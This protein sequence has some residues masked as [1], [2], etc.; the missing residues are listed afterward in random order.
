MT[1][2]VQRQTLGFSSSDGSSQLKG[3]LWRSSA[4]TSSPRGIVQIVHGMSEYVG[5]YEEFAEALAAAGFVVC[6][7]DHIG[8]GKSVSDAADLG[9]IPLAAGAQA[10]IDDVDALRCLVAA[11]Y[12]RN[13]P[14]YLFGHSMGSFIVQAYLQE[15]W[16]GLAGAVLCGTGCQPVLASR[17]GNKLARLIAR[18][19]GER[20]VSTLLFRLADGAYARAVENPRTSFDWLSHNESNVD[21]Y[22]ADELCGARFTAAG[23]AALTD[24]TERAAR[25][26]RA[27][28][29]PVDL[30]LLYIAGAEDPVGACGRGVEAAADV[31]RC[32]GVQ[33]VMV[34][35]YDG[36]RHEILN[37]EGRRQV[38]DDV[39]AWLDA[40]G[41]RP[42]RG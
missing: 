3:L 33:D 23:Y 7:H 20:A 5:R 9:H 13:T 16:A 24:L 40:H 22:C 1:D 6:G 30:P 2:R 4:G 14:Y 38:Y 11:R 10:L 8:H 37:E 17:L 42:Q 21:A 36:M 15:H 41:A 18:R 29:V 34:K 12:A 26:D 28:S 25:V 27:C 39:I 35:L 19:R 31:M 32:A